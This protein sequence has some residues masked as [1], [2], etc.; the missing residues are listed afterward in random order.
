MTMSIEEISDRL[1]IQDLMVRYSYALDFQDWD[2]MEALFTS[3]A[4]VDYS[5]MGGSRGDLATTMEFLRT[6]MPMFSSYQHLVAGS[7]IEIDGDTA[8]VRTML[9]NPMVLGEGDQPDLMLCGLWYL[10][11]LVRTPEGWK[12]KERVEK[13]SYMRILPGKK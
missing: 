1:E 5:E 2:A 13:K 11:K 9:H 10:D 8:Q 12:F 3:D 7:E 4:T 6:T